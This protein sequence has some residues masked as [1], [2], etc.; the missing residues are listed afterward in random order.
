MQTAED[1]GSR[2]FAVRGVRVILESDLARLYG[3]AVKRLNEQ[4]RRNRRRFPADF[5]FQLENQD[6]AILKSQNATSSWGGKRK[7]PLAFAEHGALMAAAVI[8]SPRAIEVSIY[9][10]RA[11]VQMRHAVTPHRDLARRLDQLE[12]KIGTHDHAIAQILDAIRQLTQQPETSPRQRI[13][14]L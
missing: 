12:R 13:G 4:V 9:V 10:V 8:N 5:V 6:V 3:V 7:P 14:F 1:I 2:I 11:F